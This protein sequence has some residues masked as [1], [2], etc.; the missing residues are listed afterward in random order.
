MDPIINHD[1]DYFKHY[2][3][4]HPIRSLMAVDMPEESLPEENLENYSFFL[5]CSFHIKQ[6]LIKSG[7]SD[8][9]FWVRSFQYP[10]SSHPHKYDMRLV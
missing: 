5:F 1:Q 4:P 10:T 7:N 9:K 3:V 2:G 8:T 6:Y